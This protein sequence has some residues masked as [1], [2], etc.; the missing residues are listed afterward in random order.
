MKTLRLIALTVALCSTVAARADAQQPVV[1]ATR[2][3]FHAAVGAALHTHDFEGPT[4]F[5]R[6][7]ELPPAAF[8]SLDGSDQ[9][10][11]ILGPETLPALPGNVLA[12]NQNSNP[13]VVDLAP[14]TNAVG[15]DLLS[16]VVGTRL[17]VTVTTPAGETS[18][19]VDVATDAP[20]FVGVVVPGGQITR[21]TVTPE[22]GAYAATDNFAAGTVVAP[23]ADPLRAALEA[24]VAC[25]SE[26][27]ADGSIRHPVKPLETHLAKVLRAYE[28]GKQPQF[29]NAL[30]AFANFVRARSGKSIH[31]ARAA[32][33][34]E[35][36]A[37]VR[38]AL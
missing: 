6:K 10:L 11:F 1:A 34:L 13:L 27:V 7:L 19:P 25:A 33:L 4:G 2:A 21:V 18:F 29:D 15:T 5:L 9:D 17:L 14:G 3:E 12:S 28:K 38:A 32:Q 22:A 30:G 37:A 16:L 23:P 8:S 36:A 35:L 31:P 26:G 24:L 20:T